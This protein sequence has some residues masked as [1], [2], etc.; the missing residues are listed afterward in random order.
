VLLALLLATTVAEPGRPAFLGATAVGL[1]YTF[2]GALQAALH[3]SYAFRACRTDKCALG[4]ALYIGAQSN[5]NALGLVT[6]LTIPFLW[7]ALRGRSRI[8]VVGYVALIVGLTGSRTAQLA[9]AAALLALVI[10]SC[11]PTWKQPKAS[12]RRR[13]VTYSR[14]SSFRRSRCWARCCPF[15]P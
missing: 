15:W 2:L 5:E 4:G 9:G 8:A 11:A 7:L 12:A 6:A 3:P 13:G 14:S 1:A 10:L